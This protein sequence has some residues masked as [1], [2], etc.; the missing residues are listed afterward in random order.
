MRLLAPHTLILAALFTLG[1][2]APASQ[3]PAAKSDTAAESKT[4]PSKDAALSENERLDAW[5]DTQYNQTIRAYPQTLTSRGIDERQDEWNDPS[6]SFRLEQLEKSREALEEM[7]A[8]FDFEALDDTRQLSY[9]LFEKN[10]EDSLARRKWWDHNYTYTQMRGAHS[11]LPTFLLNQHKIQDVEDAENY[12]KRL[13][14]LDE[15]LD[16]HTQQAK[17]KFEKGI[18]PPKFVYDF[19]IESSQ[20]IMAGNPVE[21]D[22]DELNL[23]LADFSKKV[24]RLEIEDDVREA[25]YE[26]AIAAI[27]NDVAPA[28]ERIIAEMERQKAAASTDDG[29]WKLP[30]G[31]A[32]YASR[33]EQMTTTDM[34]ADA[35]H[36]LGLSEVDRIHAEMREIMKKVEFD[37][38]LQEFFEFT[39]V[40]KQ[41]FKPEGAEG[42]A[43]YL[44]E[45]TKFIDDMKLRLPEVFNRIPKAELEVRAV[46]AFREKAAGKAFY[47]RPSPDGSRPGIYYA[48]LYRMD[49]MPVYQMEALAYHEGVPGHH[50]QLSI[51]QELEGIPAFRKFGRFTAYSEG[52]GLYSEYLPK[53]MGLYEDPYSDFG[54]LAMELWRA[55]RLVVDTGLHEKKWSREKAAQYLITNTPNPESDCW[56]AI[57]RY[58]VMPGQATAYK[59][60]MN[61]ILELREGAK[62][63]LGDDFDIRDFHDAILATGPV[64]LDIM[65]E[66][67][68]AYVAAMQSG[69]YKPD[70]L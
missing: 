65:E 7:R 32:Y 67:V 52:W 42:R 49:A 23:L 60:G 53:E 39:R 22:S 19:V 4:V 14:T 46:E 40:D 55:A 13:E 54:R 43:A 38:T 1:A 12:L 24:S 8:N 28:Y 34:S 66:Q 62:E 63:K 70:R 20:N 36:E 26:R 17:A 2:C 58:I 9:R 16:Q 50:M 69:S 37:G 44:K 56:K 5:F 51:S 59:I 3:V 47:N 61:K 25:L 27:Q 57:E 33:L 48:N 30:D 64:P 41:F 10:V 15:V 68:D 21:A 6:R 31:G 35:I 11:F 29:A 18:A 45:A